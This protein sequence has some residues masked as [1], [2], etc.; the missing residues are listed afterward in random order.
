VAI[1]GGARRGYDQRTPA[2]GCARGAGR[3]EQAS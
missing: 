2:T 3:E 1:A